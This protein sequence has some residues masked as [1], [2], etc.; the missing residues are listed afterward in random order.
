MLDL[1][2]HDCTI[3]PEDSCDCQKC[4]TC[5]EETEEEEWTSTTPDNDGS[6]K[7]EVG[8]AL[9]CTDETCKHH[10]EAIAC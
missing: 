4:P 2:T 1:D 9:Y 5:G 7:E 8:V 6:P 3:S 10:L